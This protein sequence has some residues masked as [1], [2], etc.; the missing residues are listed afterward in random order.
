MAASKNI[1]IGPQAKPPPPTQPAHVRVP[2]TSG[3][4][5]PASPKR[6]PI[7]GTGRI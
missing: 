3:A 4:F 6:P 5:P 7:T 2:G 1:K